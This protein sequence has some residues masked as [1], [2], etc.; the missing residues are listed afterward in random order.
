[1]ES[2]RE[3]REE[4]MSHFEAAWEIFD[5]APTAG[6]WSKWY[7]ENGNLVRWQWPA[8]G[9]AL[10]WAQLENMA[11]LRATAHIEYARL[12]LQLAE[13]R[14]NDSCQQDYRQQSCPQPTAPDPGV[15]ERNPNR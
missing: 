1:M 9:D 10:G 13:Q 2:P 15:P 7:D 14:L 3:L 5:G 8:D 12:C 11:S 4:A 6:I